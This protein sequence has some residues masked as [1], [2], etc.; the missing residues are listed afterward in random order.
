MRGETPARRRRIHGSKASARAFAHVRHDVRQLRAV[1]RFLSLRAK[2]LQ[3]NLAICSHPH[4]RRADRSQ[5][6][7]MPR[8]RTSIA[9]GHR[10]GRAAEA[11]V[12]KWMNSRLGTS[13]RAGQRSS[14]SRKTSSRVSGKESARAGAR[15]RDRSRPRRRARLSSGAPTRRA[16]RRALRLSLSFSRARAHRARPFRASLGV[17]AARGALGHSLKSLGKLSK[18]RMKI[19]QIANLNIDFKY[20]EKTVKAVGIGPQDVHDGNGGSSSGSSGASSC[21][22]PS[23]SSRRWR[24]AAAATST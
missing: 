4:L 20:L 12:Q 21:T 19:Q 18:G 3:G 16:R 13:T 1:H 8:S 2:V 9:R 11:G 10:M 24:R 5:Y 23:P 15:A 6:L 14:I 17:Y 22:S 7:A